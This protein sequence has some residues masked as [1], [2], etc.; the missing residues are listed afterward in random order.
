RALSLAEAGEERGTADRCRLQLISFDLYERGATP[1]IAEGLTALSR[2]PHLAELDIIRIHRLL[3][4]TLSD[5]AR[6]QQARSAWQRAIDLALDA[7]SGSELW[8]SR[9]GLA[10]Y[11]L[12]PQGRFQQAQAIFEGA[13]AYFADS[14][15][16]QYE[17]LQNRLNLHLGQGDWPKLTQT[18]A[19][20]DRLV[21]Q[22]EVNTVSNQIWVAYARARLAIAQ[23]A[24]RE[25][26]S[27]LA[28]M[29]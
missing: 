20:I 3:A 9:R 22:I 1:E 28:Q 14:P 25:A 2:S 29:A 15:G 10:L 4:N 12:L 19:Q 16:W 13:L 17:L 24:F 5:L 7:E 27:H 6:F 8:S 23:G 26:E 18:L 21:E 11:V